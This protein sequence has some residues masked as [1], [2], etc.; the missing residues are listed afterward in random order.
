MNTY[1]SNVQDLEIQRQRLEQLWRPTPAE[2]FRQVSGRWLRAVGQ[3]LVNTLAE[4]DQLRIWTKETKQG[5]YWFVHNPIDG[6]HH[7]F[8]SEESLRMWIEQRYNG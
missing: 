1:P 8:D 4:G 5:T 6:R 3:W 2:R 7:R